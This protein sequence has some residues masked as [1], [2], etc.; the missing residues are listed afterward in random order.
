MEEVLLSGNSSIEQA[1]HTWHWHIPLY[2]FL[3]GIAA[4]LLFFSALYTILGK[5]DKYKV[6]VKIGPMIACAAILI[7]L[8]ALLLDLT[9]KP[10]FWRL[11]T[12][13]RLESPMSWGAWTLM[14]ITPLAFFWSASFLKEIMPKIRWSNLLLR[15]MFA[16]PMK[17]Q[18]GE[19]NWEWRWNWLRNFENYIAKQRKNIAKL[20][21]VLA[22]VLGIY[23]GIL[24]S[25][26]NARPLWN[27]SILG[28]I[29]L[30]SGLSTAAALIMMIS[31]NHDEK[32]LFGK[33]DLAMIV[34]ELF[35][36]THLFMGFLASNA[37]QIE[38]AMLFLG[39]DY[40]KPFWIF[41]IGLG[42]VLP[43]VLEYIEMRGVKVPVFIIAVLVLIGGIMFRFIMVDAGQSL[44]YG[45]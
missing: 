34:V 38:A 26:F 5:E 27:T 17:K 24:L 9:N 2:L 43:A 23:T 10:Y 13:I 12:T 28:P 31:K 21:V 1:A 32:K 41:V 15:M 37:V 25:A 4:G 7:G 29:F 42:L 20:M 18:E 8:V 22:P 6:T 19:V 40:T 36:I 35:L 44:G 11:Y 33:I 16:I 3:G 30:V 39:G 14:L 45:F